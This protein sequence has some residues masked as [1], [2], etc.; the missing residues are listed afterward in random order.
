MEYAIGNLVLGQQVVAT[1][2]KVW[3]RALDNSDQPTKWRVSFMLP[4]GWQA[5]MADP[6]QLSLA[7]GRAGDF[8]VIRL[9]TDRQGNGRVPEKQIV[10][11]DGSLGK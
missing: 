4:D 6:F 5:K 7:D 9:P 11:A 8:T 10:V 2:L 3:M 1:G